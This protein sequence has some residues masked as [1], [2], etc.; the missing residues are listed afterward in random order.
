MHVS[1]KLRFIGNC[2]IILFLQPELTLYGKVISNSCL[3]Q[4]TTSIDLFVSSSLTKNK[5]WKSTSN[6]GIQFNESFNL[7][8]IKKMN[9]SNTIRELHTDL[10]Y[11]H[12]IDSTT[13][14]STDDIFL[15]SIWAFMEQPHFKNSFIIN[16][17]SQLTNTWEYPY[18]NNLKVRKWKSGPLLPAN[19]LAG[20][21][22]NFN[23][24][25][26]SYLNISF[27]T[28]KINSFPKTD[29]FPVETNVFASTNKVQFNSEYGF[30]L[31]SYIR[32]PL[33][34]NFLMENRTS[35][36]GNG[37]DKKTLNL[38]IQNIFSLQ[39]SQA[40]KIRFENK[41]A[42]EHRISSRIQY[43]FEILIGY[44]FKK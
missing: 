38:D 15:S 35:L 34:K 42:Y 11:I 13:I 4:K 25:K 17:K 29:N 9:V 43:R 21:G 30:N 40:M 16:L 39:T 3:L 32:L 27:A 28:I 36:F 10:S 41:V 44:S 33:L 5:D 14:K 37:I 1:R 6:S 2:L 8:S 31:Q 19:F 23:I 20:Y 7:I 26:T 18:I 12:F 22:I 24:G